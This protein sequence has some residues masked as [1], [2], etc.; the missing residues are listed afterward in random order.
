MVYGG[1][2][3]AIVVA[4]VMAAGSLPNVLVGPFA[5]AFV[6]R[7]PR[8]AALVGSDLARVGLVLLVPLAVIVHPV[9]AM[10]L[11]FTV[12]CASA[13]FL[14]AKMAA[15]ADLVPPEQLDAA[16]GA[17]WISD[18]LADIIGYPIA[19]ILVV[20]LGSAVGVA[21]VLDALS[22]LLSA[23]LL[24]RLHYGESAP[25]KIN[26][27]LRGLG[28]E[29]REG[30]VFL[31]KDP[32]LFENT[33][34]TLSAW[35]INGV[36]VA[37]LVVYA[38]NLNGWLLPYPGNFSALDTFFG[39]G[40]LIGSF[41]TGA[42]SGHIGRRFLWSFG[43][44]SVAVIALGLAPNIIV[45]LAAVGAAS[46]C[47]IIWLVATQTLFLQRTPKHLIGRVLAMRRT[48]IQGASIAAVLI[49]GLVAG[50]VPAATIITIVGLVALIGTV[51][52]LFRPALRHPEDFALH[53]GDAEQIEMSPTEV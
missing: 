40:A 18:S 27:A 11:V 41:V 23:L 13:V 19:G 9:L 45:A 46:L 43:L 22:Y 51:M 16:N 14:P 44:M 47:N 33:V 31:I 4:E 49:S 48:L 42:L 39:V 29:V 53:G 36:L 50:I 20:T 3:S 17:T 35:V 26:L 24:V 8:K 1:T 30:V 34:L 32:P 10:I 5:G 7:L 15:V 25:H 6:D 37:L 28:S 12:G 2:G 52:G 21:F 38:H